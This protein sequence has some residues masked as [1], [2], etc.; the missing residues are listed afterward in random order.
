MP[1]RTLFCRHWEFSVLAPHHTPALPLTDMPYPSCLRR[2]LGSR[3]RGCCRPCSWASSCCLWRRS[4]CAWPRCVPCVMSRAPHTQA[5]AACNADP[6]AMLHSS[7]PTPHKPRTRTA[8][9]LLSHTPQA[10]FPAVP[11]IPQTIM[12]KGKDFVDTVKAKSFV[13]EFAKADGT[14]PKHDADSADGKTTKVRRLLLPSC[15]YASPP[16]PVPVWGKMPAVAPSWLSS[17]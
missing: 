4:G 10:F 3:C 5:C 8:S 12:D 2:S 6:R 7:C 11:A 17:L 1:A 15:A 9:L 13:P 16:M 14:L